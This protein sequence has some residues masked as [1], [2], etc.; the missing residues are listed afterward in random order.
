VVVLSVKDLLE[1]GD[2]LGSQVSIV[3]ILIMSPNLP[4]SMAQVGP[5]YR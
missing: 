3:Q 4:P 5:R 2:G 1:G